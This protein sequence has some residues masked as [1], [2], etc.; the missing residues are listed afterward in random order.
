[1]ADSD[2][3]EALLAEDRTFP[4]PD[5]FAARALISDSTLFDEASKDRLAFLLLFSS[6]N[7]LIEKLDAIAPGIDAPFL[8]HW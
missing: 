7:P 8:S 4:P 2:A 5:G 6:A 1:M 3:I